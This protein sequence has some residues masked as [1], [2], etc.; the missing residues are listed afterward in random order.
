MKG[1]NARV[2]R[3]QGRING[4]LKDREKEVEERKKVRKGGG[5]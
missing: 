2:E 1:E 5:G 3:K 4:G